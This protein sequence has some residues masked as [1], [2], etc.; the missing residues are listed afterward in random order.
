MHTRL[1]VLNHL[2]AG[3]DRANFS[4][5]WG[6]PAPCQ[7]PTDAG[8]RAALLQAHIDGTAAVV[9]Y[10]PA[11]RA[12]RLVKADPLRLA[13]VTPRADGF[14]GWVAWDVDA[15]GPHGEKGLANPDAAVRCIAERCGFLGLGEPLVC[16]SR[17]GSG[18]HGWLILGE[19]LS[20]PDAALLAAYVAAAARTVADWDQADYGGPHAFLRGDGEVAEPGDAGALEIF[21]R[22]S[23]RPKHGY[24]LSAPFACGGAALDVFEE[25]PR[26]AEPRPTAADA[27]AVE[28]VL[29]EAR[30]ELER[31]QKRARPKP[32]RT[33]KPRGGAR[34]LDART[35]SLLTGTT[36][37]GERNRA[38]YYAV[39]DLTFCGRT[40]GEAES[41][42]AD[43]AARCGV[44]RA[45]ARATIRS[46]LRRARRR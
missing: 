1:E 32:R 38:L 41:M 8:E 13:A 5:P 2:F 25:P 45:E 21:P 33:P 10:S 11:G 18:R 28:R 23:E 40:E 15:A 26:P 31:R 27:A 17:S 44:P 34:R 4:A 35:E 43:A 6:A 42:L 7:L 29:T 36:P 14:C 30:A 39:A 24:P 37:E 16:A 19:P 12:A 20:L 9:D 46:G 22:S 3:A